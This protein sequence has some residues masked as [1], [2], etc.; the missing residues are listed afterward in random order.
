MP[1]R[2]DNPPNPWHSTS[3]ELLGPPPDVELEVYEEE[4]KSI[5]SRNTSA[6]LPFEWSLNPYRGCF[7]ACAYCYARPTH[8]YLDWGA[9]TD[10]ERRIVVKTNAPDLL[11]T[12]LRKRSWQRSWIAFSGVTDCY[13]PLEASYG[14][15]RRCLEICADFDNPVSIVTKGPLIER[16]LD[17]LTRVAERGGLEVSVSI[18]F[19]SSDDARHIEPFVAEPARRFETVRRL[20]AAGISTG[21]SIA[22]LI[23]GLNDHAIPELVERAHE[24]GATRASMTMVRLDG[25]VL[26]V[27]RARLEEAMPDRAKKVMHAIEEVRDGAVQERRIGVRMVGQGPRWAIA[28]QM[29]RTHCRKFGLEIASSAIKV[30]PPRGRRHTQ[31]TLWGKA[32]DSAPGSTPDSKPGGASGSAEHERA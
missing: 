1:R 19:A 18:P 10:F 26:P 20:A 25:T 28:D 6:D 8:E 27:F 11:R 30:G 32:S 29:L 22:P 5:L 17:V 23:P 4:A 7:H 24:A 2:A 16:D 13:Q 15:T 12:H 21:I 31:G 3:V 14:L 9:G